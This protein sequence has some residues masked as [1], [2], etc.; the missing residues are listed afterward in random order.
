MGKKVHKWYKQ[1][2]LHCTWSTGKG[3]MPGLVQEK[4]IFF[5]NTLLIN[6]EKTHGW[7]KISL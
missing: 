6:E 4:K 5:P 7:I 1:F 3:S 2:F